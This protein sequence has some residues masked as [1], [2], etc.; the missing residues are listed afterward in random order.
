MGGRSRKWGKGEVKK[1]E[2]FSKGDKKKE[3][4]KMEGGG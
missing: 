1:G 4:K 3:K 2:A